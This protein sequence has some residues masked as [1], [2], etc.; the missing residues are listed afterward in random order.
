MY[1]FQQVWARPLAAC[2]SLNRDLA[3]VEIQS[4]KANT[5]RREVQVADLLHRGTLIH[6]L[7]SEIL[8]MRRSR[9]VDEG[10]RAI[11][12]VLE[13]KARLPHFHLPRVLLPIV[14][15]PVLQA[16]PLAVALPGLDHG[17]QVCLHLGVDVGL[18]A[19]DTRGCRGRRC[20][21]RLFLCWRRCCY[22]TETF[23]HLGL[24]Q[25]GVGLVTSSP[26]GPE[27]D[28]RL[29]RTASGGTANLALVL[30]GIGLLVVVL[31][32]FPRE[33]CQGVH[34]SAGTNERASEL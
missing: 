12:V 7:A 19:H 26:E 15:R 23:V 4:K 28:G 29:Y 31:V 24:A 18:R 14:L 3:A 30:L 6:T 20:L 13:R 27:V 21:C 22:G 9:A 25:G 34:D 5:S 10:I 17:L 32:L 33:Q 2:C 16:R 8:H 1:N 11:A